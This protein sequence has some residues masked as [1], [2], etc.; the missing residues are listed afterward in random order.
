MKV[1]QQIAAA[2]TLFVVTESTA[3][4]EKS[5]TSFLRHRI[6][7]A[8]SCANV[9]CTTGCSTENPCATGETC[10]PCNESPYTECTASCTAGNQDCGGYYKCEAATTEPTTTTATTTSATTVNVGIGEGD[11]LI[12]GAECSGNCRDC[13]SGT[14]INTQGTK[15]CADTVATAAA[16][17]GGTSSPT[18]SPSTG[19]TGA[20]Q[21][22]CQ[23]G[24]V[25]DS[26]VGLCKLDVGESCTMCSTLVEQ[27]VSGLSCVQ[28]NTTEKGVDCGSI[29]A[30]CEL[31]R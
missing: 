20:C 4:A 13:C 8:P 2:F 15:T 27:C 18:S 26:T 28:T 29:Q 21:V 24:E 11:C 3:L 16:L 6:L 5:G 10:V 1:F 17:V 7:P 31:V 30:T 9:R 19:P 12:M 23:S 14:Y 25:C 22:A